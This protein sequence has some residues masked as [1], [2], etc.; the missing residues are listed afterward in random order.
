MGH[1]VKA[2]CPGAL[3][4]ILNTLVQLTLVRLHRQRVVGTALGDP[5]GNLPLAAHSVDSDDAAM[6]VQH[7]QQLG[8]GGDLVGFLVSLD[9]AHGQALLRRPGADHVNGSFL[10][11]PVIGTSGRLPINGHHFTRQQFS[12][13]LG[14][15]DEAVLQLP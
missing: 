12:D 4:Q 7:L 2:Q 3:E 8:N 11:G 9:L 10:P 14:S 13:G 15:G 1:P 5:L 6:Q